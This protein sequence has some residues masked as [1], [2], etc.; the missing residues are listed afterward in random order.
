MLGG[1]R[2]ASLFHTHSYLVASRLRIKLSDFPSLP[3]VV[4]ACYTHL[5]SDAMKLTAM[6]LKQRIILGHSE[7]EKF[8]VKPDTATNVHGAGRDK[9]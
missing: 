7:E 9:I 5:G 3:A 2:H 4:R 6:K 1:A 8:P